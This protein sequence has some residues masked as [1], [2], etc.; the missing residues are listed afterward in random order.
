MKPRIIITIVTET[1]STVFTLRKGDENLRGTIS[2]G[3]SKKQFELARKAIR[4]ICEA[5]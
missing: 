1:G 4:Q 5:K 2:V 3:P